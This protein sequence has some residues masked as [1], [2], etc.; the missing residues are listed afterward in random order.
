MF[1]N[2]NGKVIAL[3]F[4]IRRK[5]QLISVEE[6]DKSIDQL[7][8]SAKTTHR[9]KMMLI[10]GLRKEFELAYAMA[11]REYPNLTKSRKRRKGSS[12]RVR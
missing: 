4:K 8:R 9:M 5:K 11:P 6:F 12:S 10:P 7:V 2:D 1:I 3:G